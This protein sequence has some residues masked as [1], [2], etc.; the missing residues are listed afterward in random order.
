M[1]MTP[2]DSMHGEAGT[3]ERPYDLLRSQ[4]AAAASF[5]GELDPDLIDQRRD[6]H[7]VALG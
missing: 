1:V 4:P 5:R 2:L 7:K 6:G 3:V